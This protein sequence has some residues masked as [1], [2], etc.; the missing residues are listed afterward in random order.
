MCTTPTPSEDRWDVQRRFIRI[1]QEHRGGMVEFEFAI[2]EP[3]L[4]VE[5]IMPYPQ[6]QE[7]CAMQAVVPTQGRLPRHA[8][9]SAEHEW[10]WNL[11]DAR[12]KNFRQAS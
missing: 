5:M 3:E 2:G 11:R 12:E 6:F 9:G 8:E 1:V 10:D 7:F 4:F